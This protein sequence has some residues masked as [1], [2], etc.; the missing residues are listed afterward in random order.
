MYN[1]TTNKTS[2]MPG[3][4]I[5]VPGFQNTSTM[6]WLDTSKASEGRY[7]TDIVEALLPLGYRR[8]ENIVGAPYDWRQAPS[9]PLLG[10][11]S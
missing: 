1:R 8:G 5:D 6:E 3:V 4:L 11:L 7:F 9:K 10:S 2:S